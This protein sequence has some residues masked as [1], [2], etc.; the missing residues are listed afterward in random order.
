MRNKFAETLYQCALENPDICVVVADISP[1]GSMAKFREQHPARFINVGVAE[2]TMIGFCAGLALKGCQPFAYT[3]ATFSLYRPF[4]M[5]RN[6]LCY[7]NLPV[8]VVGMGTGVVYSTLGST[9]HTQEDVAVASAI[10]NLRILSPC[11]PIETIEA[12]RYCAFQ[13]EGPVYLRLGKTGEPILT[14]KAVEPFSFGRIRRIRVG[15]DTAILAYGPILRMGAAIA[16]RLE[17]ERGEFVSLVSVHTLKPF[18]KVGVAEIIKS[19]RRVV[20]IEENVPHGGLGSRVKEIAWDIQSSA[21]VTCFS[22]RDEFIHYYGEHE[23]L[24]RKHGIDENLIFSRLLA[25]P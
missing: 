2:Q 22:L 5:V 19:H 11:D 24:L 4:E 25:T 13:K 8:T 15:R 23:E 20:V 1:A 3:I 21:E 10:P 16:E 7:Q 6:D 14:D 12:T 18:D 17:R 9:H